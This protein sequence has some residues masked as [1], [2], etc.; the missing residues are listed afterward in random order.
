MNTVDE[1]KKSAAEHAV[2]FIESGMVIGLGTGSTTYYAIKRISDLIQQ[3]VLKNILAIPSSKQTEQLALQLGIPLTN[4]SKFKQVDITID[5]ADEVD[6]N[7]N[8]IKGGGGAL[9]REKVLA[10][11]SKRFFIVVDDSKVSEKLGEKWKVP[12]EVIPFAIETETFF[13]KNC[14]KDAAVRKNNSGEY[15]ITDEG[16]YI[17]DVNFGIIEN[18]RRTASLLNERAG[19]VEHGLF[20]DCA[21]RVFVASKSGVIT[22]KKIN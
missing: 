5:G 10:Q 4:F 3:D 7:L 18:P 22:L 16:N 20:V 14:S 9:L 11:A 21:S 19:I 13:L 8:L 15:F 6:D 17:V 1:L 12:V 2:N